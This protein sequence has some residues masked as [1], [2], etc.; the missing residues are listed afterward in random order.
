MTYRA[1]SICVLVGV[2][3]VF[4]FVACDSGM[5]GTDAPLVGDAGDRAGEEA[6]DA[7]KSL[8][9]E[10]EEPTCTPECDG[11]ECGDDGCGGVCGTCGSDDVCSDGECVS[12]CSQ[13]M[14]T[15]CAWE[16]EQCEDN[17]ECIALMQCVSGCYSDSCV[18]SCLYSY[19]GGAD[20]LINLL[21]CSDDSC[22]SEC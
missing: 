20:D 4:G 3:A 17:W 15:E 6:D 13:C 19:L 10:A 1:I 12:E 22:W 2:M 5:D 18:E 11:A 14:S 7:D 21:E 9:G 8:G 16:A